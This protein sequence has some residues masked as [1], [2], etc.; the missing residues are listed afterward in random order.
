MANSGL[1]D[2]DQPTDAGPLLAESV[3]STASEVINVDVTNGVSESLTNSAISGTSAR[4]STKAILNKELSSVEY[5]P[6]IYIHKID[7]NQ[8]HF[9]FQT[10]TL[11]H[12]VYL[13]V[14]FPESYP[15]DPPEFEFLHRTTINQERGYAIIKKLRNT[16]LGHSNRAMPCLDACLKVYEQ[17]METIKKEERRESK[18]AKYLRDSNVPFPRISGARFCGRGQ[19]VCFGWTYRAAVSTY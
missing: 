16:A 6:M 11:K 7:L 5:G 18:K 15:S 14:R 4:P 9:I 19:L 13:D 2:G 10:D 1:N 12:L 17:E 8:R 3:I